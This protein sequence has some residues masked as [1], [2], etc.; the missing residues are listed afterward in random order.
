MILICTFQGKIRDKILP[1]SFCTLGELHQRQLCI[2]FREKNLL[3]VYVNYS[4]AEARF[5]LDCLFISNTFQL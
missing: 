3:L 4:N 2:F 1:I 5:R